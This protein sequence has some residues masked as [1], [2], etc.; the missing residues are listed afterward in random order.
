MITSVEIGLRITIRT[1]SELKR[2]DDNTADI[3]FFDSILRILHLDG[4]F[5]FV[6]FPNPRQGRFKC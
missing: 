6:S 5:W 1:L 4:S 2:H 3:F